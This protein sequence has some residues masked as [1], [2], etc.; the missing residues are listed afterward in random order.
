MAF[1]PAALSDDDR[2]FLEA[3]RAKSARLARQRLL[4]TCASSGVF[5]L[6]LSPW[7]FSW[8][9]MGNLAPLLL[10]ICFVVGLALAIPVRRKL[11][12]EG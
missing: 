11:H 5:V 2:A 9:V 7:L 3:Q 10:I 4:A 8:F 12:P 1:D 6:A